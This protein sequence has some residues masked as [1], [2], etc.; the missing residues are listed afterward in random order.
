MRNAVES[1]SN[2]ISAV[3]SCHPRG[4]IKPAIGTRA[5]NFN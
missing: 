4:P 5:F 1:I 2:R 3:L